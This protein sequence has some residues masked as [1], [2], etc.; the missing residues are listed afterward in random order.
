MAGQVGVGG[1]VV[2]SFQ[3]LVDDDPYVDALGA[4]IG[5][6]PLDGTVDE[7]VHGQIDAGTGGG[8]GPPDCAEPRGGFGDHAQSSVGRGRHGAGTGDGRAV[9]AAGAASR[10]GWGV[11][12]W[13]RSMRDRVRPV[14]QVRDLL[15]QLGPQQGRQHSE[16]DDAYERFALMAAADGLVH[17]LCSTS[18]AK[19]CEQ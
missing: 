13:S 11:V 7:V 9:R 17:E 4:S 12:G 14:D 3:V 10:R 8:D 2:A 15:R 16:H 6:A 1:L 18:F 19:G 5:Q